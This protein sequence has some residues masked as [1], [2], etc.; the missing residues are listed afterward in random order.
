M[1]LAVS[2]GSAGNFPDH[3]CLGKT[4]KRGSWEHMG[5]SPLTMDRKEREKRYLEATYNPQSCAS[6]ASLPPRGPLL[7]LPLPSYCYQLGTKRST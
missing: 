7:Q 1:L 2:D 6:T 5:R 4:N 3:E